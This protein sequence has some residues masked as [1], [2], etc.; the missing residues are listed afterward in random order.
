MGRLQQFHTHQ[1]GFQRFFGEECGNKGR[2]VCAVE[3]IIIT[4]S[5]EQLTHLSLPACFGGGAYLKLY[6]ATTV[7]C[8][9]CP[10]GTL[11]PGWSVSMAN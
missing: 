6:V 5:Y 8:F 9:Q 3:Q 10:P 2:M 11:I 1:R 4:N 7:R